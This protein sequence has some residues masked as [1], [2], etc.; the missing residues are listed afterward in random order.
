M[1]RSWVVGLAVLCGIGIAVIPPLLPTGPIGGN[2]ASALLQSGQVFLAMGAIFLG[3]LLTSL[4]PCVYPLIPIT[5]GVFG[6]RK[7]ESKGRAVVLTSAYVIG[8]GVIFSVLGVVAA[9]SGKAFGSALGNQWVAVGLAVFLLVLRG[10]R[11]G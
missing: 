7:A 4:T 5:V 8:M 1:S 2:Q 9:F 11:R 10:W 3:G 6:A